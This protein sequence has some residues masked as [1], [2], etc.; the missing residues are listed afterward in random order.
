M[1]QHKLVHKLY[2]ACFRHDAEKIRELQK[3]EFR[4]IFKHRA[5]GKSFDAKWTLVRI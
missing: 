2:K 1:K 5:E 3:E 4:K